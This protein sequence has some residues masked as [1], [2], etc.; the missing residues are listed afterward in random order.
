MPVAYIGAATG[1]RIR[2]R[3]F[4][5]RQCCGRRRCLRERREGRFSLLYTF[6][7]I[8]LLAILIKTYG[9]IIT[10]VSPA[11]ST[12]PDR[13]DN[14]SHLL[15]AACCVNSFGRIRLRLLQVS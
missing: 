12:T 3:R 6:A 9:G 13:F 5:E 1:T 4:R 8:L 2:R 14:P 11:Y 15:L 7:N 10:L